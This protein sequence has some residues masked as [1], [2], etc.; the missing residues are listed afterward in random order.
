MVVTSLQLTTQVDAYNTSLTNIFLQMCSLIKLALCVLSIA[1]Q[2]T[3]LG[4]YNEY[5]FQRFIYACAH[6]KNLMLVCTNFSDFALLGVLYIE[7]VA[8]T[9]TCI[10]YEPLI[11]DRELQ[12]E[13]EKNNISRL[14]SLYRIL[15]VKNQEKLA[16]SKQVG[17]FCRINLK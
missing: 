12:N 8:T 14:K 7:S 15:R 16:K 9:C 13:C 11:M 1:V 3:Y 6:I 5:S 4:Q 10:V 2:S 17:S